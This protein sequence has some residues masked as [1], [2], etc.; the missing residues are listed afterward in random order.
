MRGQEAQQ[1]K[2]HPNYDKDTLACRTWRGIGR[3]LF[4][5]PKDP[6]LGN[7]RKQLDRLEHK[8]NGISGMRV[9]RGDMSRQAPDLMLRSP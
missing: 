8:G 4:S 9:V 5:G 2:F 1:Q 3:G 7:L 6:E